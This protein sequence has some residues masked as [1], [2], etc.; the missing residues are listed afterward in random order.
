MGMACC[1]QRRIGVDHGGHD[2]CAVLPVTWRCGAGSDDAPKL[3]IYPNL[4]VRVAA[5]PLQGLA[6]GAVESESFDILYH[7]RMGGP[8]KNGLSLAEPWKHTV[9]IG[10]QQP[11]HGQVSSRCEQAG[12]GYEVAVSVTP[13]PNPQFRRVDAQVFDAQA[14]VLRLSTIVGRY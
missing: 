6:Q 7:A 2:P 3:V 9:R 5:K 14:P 11:A 13:T 4:A 10:L 12:R 8:P 1:M